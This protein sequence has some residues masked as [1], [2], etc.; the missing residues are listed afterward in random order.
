MQH[1]FVK[2]DNPIYLQQ[3]LSYRVDKQTDRQTNAGDNLTPLLSTAWVMMTYCKH[4]ALSARLSLQLVERHAN[5]KETA[6]ASDG[7][8]A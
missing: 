5:H 8:M 6:V 2:Y 1:S 7:C 4:D 3:F